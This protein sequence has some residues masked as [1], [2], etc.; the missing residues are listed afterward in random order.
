LKPL[1]EDLPAE[2]FLCRTPHNWKK[3]SELFFEGNCK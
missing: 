3:N 1:L 2:R